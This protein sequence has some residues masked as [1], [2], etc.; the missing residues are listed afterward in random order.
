MSENRAPSP[1]LLES[2]FTACFK[3]IYQEIYAVYGD[4]TYYCIMTDGY[5]CRMSHGK[6]GIIGVTIENWGH[7]STENVLKRE[8]VYKKHGREISIV[9][10]PRV[11]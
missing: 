2:N 3:L 4:A 5:Q 9:T 7:C 6:A 8:A 1:T 10:S 11:R